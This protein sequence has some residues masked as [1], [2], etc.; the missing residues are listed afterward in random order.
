MYKLFKSEEKSY[1][2]KW[3]AG[4]GIVA[5]S[6][7]ANL[8]SHSLVEYIFMYWRVAGIVVLSPH[9]I[10]GTPTSRLASQQVASQIVF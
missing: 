4:A 10:K 9:F 1:R 7:P 8:L 2:K 3:G 5:L 6:P